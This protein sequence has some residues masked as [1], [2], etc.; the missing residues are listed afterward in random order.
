[1]RANC[2]RSNGELWAVTETVSSGRCTGMV[3]KWNTVN[4][5]INLQQRYTHTLVDCCGIV[6]QCYQPPQTHRCVPSSI[7]FLLRLGR[8]SDNL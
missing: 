3:I 1:M 2:L 6:S 4:I 7:A 5:G 8:Q